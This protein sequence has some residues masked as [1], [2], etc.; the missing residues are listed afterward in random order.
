MS[1]K[2]SVLKEQNEWRIYSLKLFYIWFSSESCWILWK[3]NEVFAQWDIQEEHRSGLERAVDLELLVKNV[4]I[5][6]CGLQFSISPKYVVSSF[7]QRRWRVI[8]LNTLWLN[9]GGLKGETF[10]FE[11]R[12]QVGKNSREDVGWGHPWSAAIAPRLR[13]ASI[14]IPSHRGCLSATLRIVTNLLFW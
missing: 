5:T 13:N 12:S 1:R 9:W 8:W 7:I 3:Q 11:G 2:Y 6:M 4:E 14:C 10:R